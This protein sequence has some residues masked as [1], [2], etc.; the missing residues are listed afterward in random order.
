MNSPYQWYQTGDAFYHALLQE[1]GKAKESI[2]LETYIY[3][4]GYPGDDIRDA[5]DNALHRGVKVKVLIDA[6]GSMDLPSTY[7]STVTAAGGE[8]TFFNPLSYS[9]FALRNHRKLLVC[10]NK[11]AFVSGFNISGRETGDGI[12][13]GW[14]DLGLRLTGPVVH[15]LTDS[16]DR[17]VT[18]AQFRHPRLPR[19]R[20]RRPRFLH[21]QNDGPT[22]QLLASGPGGIDNTI[23]LTLLRDFHRARSI[24]IISAYFLPTRRIRKALTQ[25]ARHGRDVKII[26]AGKTDVAMAR[27]AGRALYQRLLK[28]GVNIQEYTAQILHTKLIIADNV[29]YIG[30]ANL[31]TRSLNINYELLVRIE[32]GHLAQEAREIF[33]DYLP[34]C[35]KINPNTWRQSRSWW[36]KLME[37]LSHFMLAKVDFILARRQISRMR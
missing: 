26:T 34:H 35:Q 30:S 22:P 15:D 10:D 23:K 37:R 19:L 20:L 6:F 2:R 24:R 27:Y 9:R 5:L 17:L 11:A 25:A 32:D 3:D 7:W 1:I 18:V 31:D 16:F 28:A 21:R 13:H 12:T 4:P 14:R 36:E 33:R 8:I 29:V